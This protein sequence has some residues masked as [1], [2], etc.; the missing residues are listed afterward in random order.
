MRRRVVRKKS[1][2][3]LRVN[4]YVLIC[5]F[6]AV[7]AIILALS[8]MFVQA[9]EKNS[10]T[11]ESIQ[12]ENNDTLW[13]IAERYCNTDKESISD[14]IYKV[15]ELNNLSSDNITSGNYI[16]IYTYN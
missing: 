7:F 12:I 6:I 15:K 5:A 3:N 1:S 9:E 14:Y 4:N 16:L 2:V 13:D 10:I 11:Y 8:G